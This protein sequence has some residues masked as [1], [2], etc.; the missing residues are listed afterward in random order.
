M[1]DDK[2]KVT[3]QILVNT[4]ITERVKQ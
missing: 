2:V 4:E 3:N 1:F